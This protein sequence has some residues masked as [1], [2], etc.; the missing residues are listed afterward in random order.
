MV[1]YGSR[2]ATCARCPERRP[3]GSFY[4]LAPFVVINLCRACLALMAV[5]V[6]QAAAR[7]ASESPEAL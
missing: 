3:C 2:V 7:L 5:A 1:H 4:F 6:G